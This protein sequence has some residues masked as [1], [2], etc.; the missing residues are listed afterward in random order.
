MIINAEI[1][2]MDDNNTVI[3]NGYISF[4]DGK[5]SEMG[6]MSELKQTDTDV[7]DANGRRV[8]PGFVDA[9]THLGIF[10]D[11]LTFEGDDGN[12]DTDPI[13]PQLRAIDA[14]NPFDRYFNE[15]LSAGVTTVLTSPGS[16]DPIA[17]Q[18]AAIKTF[19]KRIDKMIIK[20][21][22]AI[23]FAL[24]ENPKSTYSDKDQ[25]P[26]TRMATA[27]LIRET[28]AKAKN[29]YEEKKNY[30]ADKENYDKPE[31]DAK[32]EALIP[33]FRKEIP[34]HFHAHRA[35]DIFTAIRIS[36]E[37]DIDCVIVHA[38][39]GHLI[40]DELVSDG[41]SVLSGPFLTDRSKPE[42]KNLTPSSP[43]VMSSNGI[44]TA[45]ITD[46]PETPIQYLP[47]CAAV[48][49]REGMDRTQALR[50]ITITPAQICGISDR[51]GSIEKG[52]DADILIFD[53]SPLD[54]VNKPV[55]VIADAKIVKNLSL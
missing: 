27:S 31:Y 8:Y 4:S 37:F 44:P 14:V 18:I 23:K 5:I 26:V 55:M 16:A 13:M 10:E 45:I 34:A 43:S 19:G 47:L 9:H 30:S 6:E 3:K 36:K 15:A 29:Y 21:P 33:L 1:H 7:I 48:A 51:V 24:G 39:D 46:H 28:L 38:T 2:T 53:G 11:S 25:T 54:I 41:I 35:D 17:G 40:Y 32:C 42:L 52:K 49:V 22:V 20:A 50:A 12:E